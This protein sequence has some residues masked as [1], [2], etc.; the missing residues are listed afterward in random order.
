MLPNTQMKEL[1]GALDNTILS[2]TLNLQ[3]KH[4]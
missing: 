2:T 3:S 4:M 1:T